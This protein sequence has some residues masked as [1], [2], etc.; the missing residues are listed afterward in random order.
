[1]ATEFLYLSRADVEAVGITMAEVVAAVEEVLHEK[2]HG[3]VEMPPKRGVHPMPNSAINA[4]PGYVPLAKVAGIKWVTRYLPQPGKNLPY[5]LGLMI[6][7]EPETGLPLSVMDCAWVTAVR[8]GAASAVA[9]KYLARKDSRQIAILGCGV[10]GRSNLEAMKIVFPDLERA[11]VYDIRRDS[12]ERYATDMAKLLSMRIDVVEDP[13]AAVQDTD[14]VVTCGPIMHQPK[15]V[16][17]LAWL[18]K[19]V[20]LSAVDLDSY[21]KPEVFNAAKLYTDDVDQFMGYSRL[22]SFVGIREPIGDLGELVVGKKPARESA[23]EVTMTANLGLAVED[24]AVAA[25]VYRMAK[26]CRLGQWLPL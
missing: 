16:I 13:K 17:E 24:L 5:I 26:E 19:G 14:I 10:Q 7:N 22:G 21:I 11:K 2:G 1:M 15:P 8:T 20:F 23:D 18:K 12:A 3:R 9:A 6:L 25:R 4:M